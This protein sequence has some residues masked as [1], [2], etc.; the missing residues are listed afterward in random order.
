ML[1][2]AVIQKHSI[3]GFRVALAITRLPGMTMEYDA[4]VRQTT[5]VAGLKKTACRLLKKTQRQGAVK[6]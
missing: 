4:N 5:R 3:S 6:Y 1:A 2:K